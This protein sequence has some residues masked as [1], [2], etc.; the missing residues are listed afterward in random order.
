M[1]IPKQ[2]KLV[3]GIWL[4]DDEIHM[5]D[6][7]LYDPAASVFRE[8]KATYQIHKIDAC[9]ARLPETR[10]RVAVDVGAHVGLWSMWLAREF[11]TVQAFEPSPRH[12]DLFQANVPDAN[13]RLHRLALGAAAGR[14]DVNYVEGSSGGTHIRPGPG[15]FEIATLDSFAL[16]KIDFI[17]IDVEGF[18]REVVMGARETIL[19]CRPMICVEQKNRDVSNFGA[20]K[21]GALRL[22]HDLG[23][24]QLVEIWGDYILDWPDRDEV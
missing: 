16:E 24:R 1:G 6:M 12:T 5:V 2:A 19:S 13:V 10:R 22:L 3:G 4:P 9:L 8:G 21:K 18:E 20:E 17:K 7:L 11:E 15:D 23:M 14:C